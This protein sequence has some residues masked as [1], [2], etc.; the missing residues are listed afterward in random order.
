VVAVFPTNDELTMVYAAA[1]M[2]EFASARAD[3]DGDFL[4]AL[5][6]G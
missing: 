5:A 1:P 4:R 2:N 3:L 6:A